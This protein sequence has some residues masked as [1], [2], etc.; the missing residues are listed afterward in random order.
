MTSKLKVLDGCSSHHLQGAGVH[1]GGRTTGHTACWR[2]KATARFVWEHTNMCNLSL[3]SCT[4]YQL[5]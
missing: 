1:C 4:R 3:N 5:F 2:S